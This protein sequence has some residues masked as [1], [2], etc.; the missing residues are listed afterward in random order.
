MLETAAAEGDLDLFYLD[1]SGFCQWSNPGYSYYYSGQQKRQ[2]QTW[3]RGKR[4][5]IL[6]IWKPL[7]TLAYSL[8][9]GSFK[10]RDYVAMLDIQAA[11]ASVEYR[12]TGKIRVIVQDNGSIHTSKL[13]KQR[14][15]QWEEQGLYLFFLPPYCSEMNRIELEWL[16]TKRDELCGKMFGSES[17]LAYNVIRGL[18]KRGCKNGHSVQH[19]DIVT[20][21]ADACPC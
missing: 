10:S 12:K 18:E 11:E 4:L 20:P 17:E 16:H 1:E 13:A 14:W 15:L 7:F 19:V 9:V 6:G 8:V 2:E 3:S 5:S 21:R